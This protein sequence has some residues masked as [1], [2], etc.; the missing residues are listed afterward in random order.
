MPSRRVSWAISGNEVAL[1]TDSGGLLTSWVSGDSC[2]A[3]MA[4]ILDDDAMA[5]GAG[6][7][8]AGDYATTPTDDAYR[9]VSQAP[10]PLTGS[11]ANIAALMAGSKWTSVDVAS[12]K[13]VVTFSFTDPLTSTFDYS[14]SDY[15]STLTSFSAADR[16]VTR[17]VLARIEA[18]CNVKFVEVADNSTECGVLRY[19]YSQEPNKMNF[20][21]YTFFP[22]SGAIGGDVWIGTNQSSSQWDFYR[23]D[24]L[25]HETLHAL[26]LKHP[27]DSGAVLS[28]QQDIIANTVMSYSTMVGSTGGY[29]SKYPGEPMTL[30]IAALQYLYGAAESNTGDTRY[31]LSSAN[32]QSGFHAVWDSGGVDVLDA[33]RVGRGVTLDLNQGAS[34]DI[35]AS[36][37]ASGTVAGASV[38]TVYTATV[39]IALGAVI[40]NAVGSAFN[41]R[42]IGNDSANWLDG[43]AGDDRLEGRAGNDVLVGGPGNNILD[44]GAGVDTAVFASSRASYTITN[45]AQGLVVSG[46]GSTDTVL[47]VERLVFSDG[48]VALDLSGNAGT[49][50]KVIGAVFGAGCVQ[51]EAVVGICLSL[52]DAGMS[53]QDFV[54]LALDCRLG[55]NAGNDAVVNLLLTNLMGAAPAATQTDFFVSLI[56]QGVVSQ[57]LL[58]QIAAETALNAAQIDLVGLSNTGIDYIG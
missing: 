23:P 14:N 31:D 13:T 58:A 39:S 21:G 28:T 6:G 10:T 50:A 54:H 12:G 56:E 11:G 2:A 17:D 38:S 45:S 1:Q 37:S 3:L 51:N 46:P 29:L 42:L 34:S 16:Q 35:G 48:C 43:G 20:A 5:T 52:L 55:A 25:L 49:S 8:I 57:A 27:F 26:G 4:T 7:S 22:S 33:S 47:N 40:E 15:Q 24:L 18:V 30:D 44:G 32:F 19:G 36:V 53:E 41:D 9:Y